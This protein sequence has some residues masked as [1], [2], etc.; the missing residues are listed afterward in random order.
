MRTMRGDF[1]DQAMAGH[2]VHPGNVQLPL[3]PGVTA[4]PFAGL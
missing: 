1:G 3:G 4:H 2:V